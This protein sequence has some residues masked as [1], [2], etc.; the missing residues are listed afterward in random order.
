MDLR[1]VAVISWTKRVTN[2]EVLRRINSKLQL[3]HLNEIR[4]LKHVAHI[5]RNEKYVSLQQIIQDKR[6]CRLIRGLRMK[7]QGK[8]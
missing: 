4:K 1:A 7:N 3:M 6:G 8:W 2:E 5:M